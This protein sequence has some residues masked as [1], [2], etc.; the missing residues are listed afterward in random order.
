MLEL[1]I[2]YFAKLEFKC[3]LITILMVE[4]DL[5]SSKILL[6]L[7]IPQLKSCNLDFENFSPDLFNIMPE[8]Q[9][10]TLKISLF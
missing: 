7:K 5:A 9:N 10:C 2:F 6:V 4:M 3:V 1:G 8:I